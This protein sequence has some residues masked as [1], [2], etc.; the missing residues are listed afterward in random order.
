MKFAD[1]AAERNPLLRFTDLTLRGAGQVMFMNNPVTGLLILAAVVWGA[2]AEDLP[3]V[4]IGA[5]VGLLVGTLTA[6]A[7]K[8]D[9]DTLRQGMYGFSPLLT[10]AAVPTFLDNDAWMWGYLVI[11]AATTTVVTLAVSNVFTTWGVPALTFP[12]VLTSW[13]LM[14]GAYQFHK[15]GISSLSTPALPQPAGATSFDM[16][17]PELATSML[18]GVSQVFL[19][20]DWVSGLIILV[21]LA[22][23]SRWAA[24]LAAAAAVVATLL[25]IALGAHSTAIE[26]G[27]FGFSAVLTAIALGCVFNVPNWR[28]MLYALLGT[29]VTV[30]IQAALDTAL[31]PIGV[32]TFTA[33]FVFATWLFLLP[34]ADL[35]PTPHHKPIADGVVSGREATS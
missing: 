29:V 14:L 35:V 19:I 17:F 13:F 8:V 4:A 27:L 10:G 16:S 1:T 20:G 15:I 6:M 25:A 18:K 5:V 7:L 23:N 31:A 2:V 12:F 21:A 32:P 26:S 34:K 3:Q 24:I 22:I 9:R 33:P 28:A 11:G 30:V